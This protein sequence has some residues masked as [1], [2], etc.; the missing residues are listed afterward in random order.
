MPLA[1]RDVFQTK[2]EMQGKEL[3]NALFFRYTVD[4]LY[5]PYFTNS[6]P[7]FLGARGIGSF[8]FLYFMP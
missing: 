6:K 8:P 5:F 7:H 2:V 1:Y 4:T 3:A